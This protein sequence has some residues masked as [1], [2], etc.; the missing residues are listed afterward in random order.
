MMAA[1][2]C[3][4]AL[5][6]DPSYPQP[7]T[8]DAPHLRHPPLDQPVRRQLLD[9]HRCPR[10][11]SR[12][13]RDHRPHRLRDPLIRRPGPAQPTPSA[14]PAFPRAP[15]P[16]PRS[17][18]PFR[19]RSR[20]IAIDST[21][22]RSTS[23]ISASST[24]SSS[25]ST[26]LPLL[27]GCSGFG[28][29]VLG[30]ERDILATFS[31]SSPSTLNSL[32]YS[33]LPPHALQPRHQRRAHHQVVMSPPGRAPP[34]RLS[35]TRRH[36]ERDPLQLR[37]ERLGIHPLEPSPPAPDRRTPCTGPSRSARR[38]P[39]PSWLLLFSEKTNRSTGITRPSDRS[40]SRSA[41]NAANPAPIPVASI[42]TRSACQT[43]R[44]RSASSSRSSACFCPVQRRRS[45]TR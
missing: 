35:R 12:H 28:F 16:A 44:A 41:R 10:S 6:C 24:T 14:P 36:R 40:S 17:G 15:A 30:F 34:H 19:I 5:I 21:R 23:P 31:T 33:P 43:C 9:R 26:S 25:V 45:T 37:P 1:Y 11:T 22:N 42:T 8:L 3:I 27:L 38:S 20:T 4:D 18:F 29:W 32:R 39:T 2:P 13:H 7:S